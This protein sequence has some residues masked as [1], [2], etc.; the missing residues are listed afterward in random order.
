M[1]LCICA[2]DVD[3]VA[4]SGMVSFSL[5]LPGTMCV[6][7]IILSDGILEDLEYFFVN[8]SSNDERII[9]GSPARIGILDNDS[10]CFAKHFNRL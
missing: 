8:L 6:S 7:I 3:Y 9:L 1:T 5:D 2:E 4:T 10:K